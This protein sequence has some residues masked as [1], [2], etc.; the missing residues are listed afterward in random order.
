MVTKKQPNG[1]VKSLPEI[2]KRFSDFVKYLLKG[3]ISQ[4]LMEAMPMPYRQQFSKDTPS[5]TILNDVTVQ[6]AH[7]STSF[8]KNEDENSYM[9]SNGRLYRFVDED[10]VI[11]TQKKSAKKAI[12]PLPTMTKA[13]YNK[14]LTKIETYVSDTENIR[15][16]RTIDEFS[17]NIGIESRDVRAV[18]C[19]A[20]NKSFNKWK[21]GIKIQLAKSTLIGNPD[22]SMEELRKITGYGCLSSLFAAFKRES[23][24]VSIG[25]WNK[26]H[27]KNKDGNDKLVDGYPVKA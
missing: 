19:Y 26:R 16:L 17:A 22:I 9:I 6:S 4:E 27:V 3:N 8:Y 20:Y 7:P 13:Q 11:K 18:L 24:G 21:D 15:G 25:I 12:S 14:I 1:L 23:G 2:A 5:Y 10:D